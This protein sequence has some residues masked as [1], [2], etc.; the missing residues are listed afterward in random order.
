MLSG[1]L[2]SSG[3]LEVAMLLCFAAAWPASI[4]KSLKSRTA[5]GKS[6]IFA[7][8]I[9]AGY[10]L[11]A[12]NKI[13]I[14]SVDFVIWFYLLNVAVI[15]IDVVLWLRNRRLDLQRQGSGCA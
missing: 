8:T 4:V 9:L 6:V 5:E 12:A 3:M 1:S 10:L 2:L 15:V 13:C 11:G 7:L 14:G